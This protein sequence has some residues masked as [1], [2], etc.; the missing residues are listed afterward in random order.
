MLRTHSLALSARDAGAGRIAS[1]RIFLIVRL[2]TGIF[3]IKLLAVPCSE[4]IRDRNM[5]RASWNTVPAFGARDR[6]SRQDRARD[7]FYR[8][9]LRLA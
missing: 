7:L 3:A 4:K 8:F 9:L 5:H 1:L 6:I 2:V